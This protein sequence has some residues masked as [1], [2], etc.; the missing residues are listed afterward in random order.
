MKGRV[1]AVRAPGRDETTVKAFGRVGLNADVVHPVRLE[2]IEDRPEVTES[3]L[4]TFDVVAF[5]GPRTVDML[6]PREV[7]AIARSDVKV[8]A[9][10]PTTAKALE[11]AGVNVD[12]IPERYTTRALAERLRDEGGVLA[13]RC[14][15][16]TSDMREVLGDSLVEI[17]VYDIVEEDV[18]VDPSVYDVVCF[19]SSRTAEAFLKNVDVRDLPEPAVSIGP[20]TTRVLERAGLEVLEAPTSDLDGVVEA[21]L[22]ALRR[23]RPP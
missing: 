20:V 14:A 1:L 12:V 22:R 8:A 2:P 15:A 7:R 9:V 23:R 5:T 17:P 21:T 6:K 10:G 3:L 4:R 16:R 11:K 18:N 19:F 13:L